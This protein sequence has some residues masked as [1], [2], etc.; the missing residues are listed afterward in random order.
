RLRTKPRST[1]STEESAGAG[2]FASSPRD[3]RHTNP[4][5]SPERT[6]RLKTR[7]E[8]RGSCGIGTNAKAVSQP[9]ERRDNHIPARRQFLRLLARGLML[10]AIVKVQTEPEAKGPSNINATT[11]ARAPRPRRRLVHRERK[12]KAR[13]TAEERVTR[14]QT[15]TTRCSRRSSTVKLRS[16]M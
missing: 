3:A 8:L 5:Q 13:R 4:G 12:P 9:A 14:K 11:Q 16:P 7:A 1:I 15:S 10:L 2:S 6:T